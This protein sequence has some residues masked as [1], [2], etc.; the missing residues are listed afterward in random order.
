MTKF[1]VGASSIALLFALAGCAAS[2]G[3]STESTGSASEAAGTNAEQV[4]LEVC[5]TTDRAIAGFF[6]EWLSTDDPV[7]AWSKVDPALAP[8]QEIYSDATP[9]IRKAFGMLTIWT[10]LDFSES[11]WDPTSQYIAEMVSYCQASGVP[12]SETQAVIDNNK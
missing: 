6:N 10:I 4:S 9:E 1:F 5:E 11:T 7:T 8:A 12:M 2:S 3:D